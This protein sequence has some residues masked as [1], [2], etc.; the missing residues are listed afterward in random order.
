M[1]NTTGK[2][3]GGRKK[4]TVNITTSEIRE[5][6]KKLI[7]DNMN[8]LQSDL[9]ELEPIQ[10]LK[11][12]IELSK[13]VVPTLKAVDVTNENDNSFKPIT[14]NISPIEWIE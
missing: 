11:I 7:A 14:V 6:Y 12:I 8:Q 3:Y 5:H 4:G 10:R 1:A 13:F 2:K 9:K